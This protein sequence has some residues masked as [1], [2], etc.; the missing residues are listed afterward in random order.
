LD[1]MLSL[2]AVLSTENIWLPERDN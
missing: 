2:V 1:E